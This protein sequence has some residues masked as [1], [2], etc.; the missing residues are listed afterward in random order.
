MQTAM[1]MAEARPE[2]MA[3]PNFNQSLLKYL[4]LPLVQ[5]KVFPKSAIIYT[6]KKN[7]LIMILAVNTG[8]RIMNLKEILE[9]VMQVVK[10]AAAST[11]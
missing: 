1:D 8:M 9:L 6:V 5:V 11:T 7:L 3:R 10:V 2:V 4:T